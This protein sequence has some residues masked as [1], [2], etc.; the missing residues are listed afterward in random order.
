MNHSQSIEL[1]ILIVCYNSKKDIE[2]CLRSVAKH[3]SGVTYEIL[4]IN[5][6]NDQLESYIQSEFPQVKII[7]NQENLGFAGGNNVL[8]QHATGEKLLLLNPDTELTSNAIEQLYRVSLS[9]PQYAAWGGVTYFA[10]GAQEYSSAQVMPSLFNEFATLLGLG[11]LVR[12]KSEVDGVGWISPVLSGAFMIVDAQDW[13]KVGGFDDSFFL[14]SEEVD[15]CYRLAQ[16]KSA[17]PLMCQNASVI[18]YVGG[19]SS[20]A[21]RTVWLLKGKMHFEKKHFPQ[22]HNILMLVILYSWVASRYLIG[23]LAKRAARSRKGCEL[24]ERF[25]S[26]FRDISVW[27]NGYY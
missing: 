24:S 4:L 19:S 7:E 25:S 11:A 13:R 27:R 17:K 21:S 20:N 22:W 6:A 10:S 26:A 18:H 1:S 2:R 15:L 23:T 16:V 5:N 14:Y 12:N 9:K 8:A 3:T